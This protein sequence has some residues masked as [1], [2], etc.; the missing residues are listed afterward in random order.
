MVKYIGTLTIISTFIFCTPA[1]T[2]AQQ[3]AYFQQEVDYT[4]H[5]KLNDSKHLLEGQMAFRYKNNS[6]DTLHFIYIHLW[7]NGYKDLNTA[8]A[9]QLAKEN[10]RSYKLLQN[11]ANR[12]Q[13]NGLAFESLGQP[14]TFNYDSTNKDFGKILLNKP[15]P[16]QQ[17][18]R[19][20]TPFRVKIPTLGISRMGH[21]GQYY[22]ITQWF[23][24][25]AVY[26]NK[27][28]HAMPYLDK[29]EFY[30][31]YGAF[32]VYITV[33]ANYRVA[34]TGQLQTQSEKAWLN[35]L[36]KN[37][38]QISNFNPN[39]VITPSSSGETKTLHYTE[40]N[41]HDF[42]WF[43]DKRFNV[44][45]DTVTLPSGHTIQTWAYFTNDKG[46]AWKKA[47]TYINDALKYYS[48]WYGEY[49]YSNCTAVASPG[50][51]AGGGMEYPT[52]TNIGPTN[53]D[54]MLEMV[55]M[56]EVGHNWFYGMLGF[57]ER[58]YPWLDEGIN[59]FSET[60]YMDT[61]YGDEAKLYKFISDDPKI[62][63]I[64]GIGH[65]TYPSYHELFYRFL[66]SINQ[67][68][69]ANLHSIEYDM[70]N[71]GGILYSKTSRIFWHLYHYMGKEEFDN[72]M[73]QFF[74]KW[75]YRHPGPDDL[76]AHFEKSTG[77]DLSWVFDE[78]IGTTKKMDYKVARIK[79]N[80]V[81][82]KNK[83]E[84][85]A[86]I[87]LSGMHADS[88]IFTQWNQGFEGKQW[89]DIPETSAKKVVL[90]PSKYTMEVNRQNNTIRTKGIAKR[91]EP[92]KFQPN[93]FIKRPDKTQIGVVPAFGWNSHNGF[94]AGGYFYSPFFPV[95][96]INY[97]LIPLY[98]VGNNGFAG[99]GRINFPIFLRS[100]ILN[101]IDL[102][103]KAK[104]FAVDN[105]AGTYYQKTTGTLSFDFVSP[106]GMP[107]SDN[108]L[109]LSYSYL[110]DFTNFSEMTHLLNGSFIHNNKLLGNPLT[111]KLG[112]EIHPDFTKLQLDLS[113]KKQNTFHIRLFA[114]TFLQKENNLP[115]AYAFHLS[116]TTG[117]E[118]YGFNHLLLG[119]G[120]NPQEEPPSL[121]SRQF[122]RTQGGF[123]PYTLI[124]TTRDFMA[125]L[126]ADV[127][128]IGSPIMGLQA[129]LNAAYF[130][131]GLT[132]GYEVG[133]VA[134]DFGAKV[135]FF[136]GILE[137][138][139][140]VAM[141]DFIREDLATHTANYG[142]RIRFTLRL[143]QADPR[144]LIRSV[145]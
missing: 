99:I 35:E 67:D 78:F 65:L 30:S 62:E 13:I 4:I 132:L 144:K 11:P 117:F 94:M 136:S 110:T 31:E 17:E 91:I 5:V 26:D 70:K 105:V 122:V 36:A 120:L 97:D 115:L 25:P 104:Q 59:S 45:K 6:P 32:D 98:G 47:N 43:A 93:A 9:K 76:R 61:K 85:A 33:P 7:P 75:Q 18:I 24:K 15:L 101:A 69:P 111:A 60:R 143:D 118:D 141:S 38:A 77:E 20:S 73:Q 133:N 34:A 87:V 40:K 23:P 86:P 129:Y 46:K 125:A 51:G 22:A 92:L 41:I 14:L 113:Y 102:T 96:G 103:V 142:E 95:D 71:Y 64:L 134:L 80:K 19:I 79:K 140:P 121:W 44:L 81:L 107:N 50:F 114:G 8:L 57:N 16:P 116:G 21:N 39:D 37:T 138:Y 127:S 109:E 135:S 56:H 139:F 74:D 106:T 55:I 58:R 2:T 28:W 130:E 48:K 124:G 10:G 29:G 27:G 83:G 108:T 54:F 1:K 126:N 100:N 3:P 123:I 72:T 68:M 63:K 128:L 49:P 88:I 12:G 137:V 119:R 84:V 53:N 145:L 90:D 42:A 112:T 66:A 89:I 52:I 82:V 131:N